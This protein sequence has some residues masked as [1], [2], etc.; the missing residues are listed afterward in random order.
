MS[1]NRL[2][3]YSLN[4]SNFKKLRHRNKIRI[5][6]LNEYKH[7]FVSETSGSREIGNFSI[8]RNILIYDQKPNMKTEFMLYPKKIQ[9]DYVKMVYRR[10]KKKI[11]K[12]NRKST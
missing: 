7:K 2:L 4:F 10:R 3:R 11:T 6:K 12:V 9:K 1:I 8:V 5:T